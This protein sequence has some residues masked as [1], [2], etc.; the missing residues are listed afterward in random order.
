[1]AK[2]VKRTAKSDLDLIGI[3]SHI[4]HDNPDAADALLDRFEEKAL[5]LA[6][7][8]KLG[9]AREDIS[10]GLRIFPVGNY[11]LLYREIPTGIELVRVVHGARNL[12]YIL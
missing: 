11:V 4:A 10:P 3:W 2:R 1:M 12:F 7:N 9:P 8:P 6:K 5:K